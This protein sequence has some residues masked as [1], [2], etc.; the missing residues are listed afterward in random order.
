M[1]VVQLL[2]SQGSGQ[3]KV[4]GSW[5]LG[6]QEIQCSRRVDNQYWP[7][8]SGILGWRTPFPDREA[9]QATFYR[10]AGSDTTEAT[11]HA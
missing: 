7:I 10:V 11:L 9:W 6:Q 8:R 2:G 3:H 1:E 4:L 5:Q